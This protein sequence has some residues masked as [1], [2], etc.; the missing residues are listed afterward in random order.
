MNNRNVARAVRIT[1]IAAGAVGAGLY[2]TASIAQEQLQEV[3]VTG[4]RIARPDLEAASPITVIGREA[5][6]ETGITDIG[7]L[8]QRVPSMSGSPIGTTTNNGGDGSVQVDLRGMGVDRTITLINGLRTVDGGDYQTIPPTM[9]ERIEVLKNG[10]SAVYGADAVAGVVNIITRKD[11]DGLEVSLQTADYFDMDRGAQNT[12]GVIIGNSFEG[13]HFVF[14]AEY[15]DQEEAYQRDAPWDFFQ[16]TYYIYPEGCEKQLTAPYTGY[17]DGG[18]YESGSSRIPEG[19]FTFATQGNYI[20]EE[21]IGLVEDDDRLYNFAPV[22]Y[23]QTPYKRTNLFAE[24]GFD[25]SETIRF[26]ASVRGNFRE[27]AQELAPMPYDTGPFL[28]PGYPVLSPSGAILNGISADN[29]YLIQAATAAGLTP[30]AVT[31]AKRR[32][33]EQPRRFEQEVN[34]FQAAA[35]LSGTFRENFDWQFTYNTGHRTRTD[36]DVGQL[37]GSK[38]FNALGP[39]ADLNDDGEPECYR[40]VNDPTSLVPGCVPMNLFGGPGTVTP[41][42]YAYASAILTDQFRER[43]D[44][45]NASVTGEAF[46]LPGGPLGWAVSLGYYD[47]QYTYSPDSAKSSFDVTGNKGEGTD[48]SLTAWSAAFEVLAPVFDNGA[49]AL[50]L[51][52]SV[53]YDDYNQLKTSETTG[54]LGF[55]FNAFADLKLRGTAGT[56]FRAPTILDLYAGRF[57]D[58]PQF[59]DPCAREPLPA[60]CAQL[61]NQP[62]SQVLS[63]NSGNPE[64][65]PESGDT[66]TLGLVWTP[67]IG[68]GALSATVDYWKIKL[69]DAISQLGIQFYLDDCYVDQNAESCSVITRDSNYEVTR[70]IDDLKNIAQQTGEGIDTELRYNLNTGIGDWEFAFLWSHLLERTKTPYAG[71]GKDDLTGRYVDPTAN[72]TS[73]AYA[74]DKINYSVRWYQ[75]GVML[76]YQGEYVSAL[77]ADTFCNCGDGNRPDGTYVQAIDAQL[78]HDFLASYEFKFG[79]KITA[80]VTN[81]TNEKPPYIEVGFNATTDPATY[82]TL[83]R[84]YYLRLSHKFE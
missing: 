28:D 37:L 32:M 58:F 75:Q 70:V 31:R 47:Q 60:G 76:A 54:Q 38:L 29:Y 52:G 39:S 16:N 1:L 72:E 56:V 45:V 14:G 13:G 50:S 25:V 35:T 73:G 51:S 15:V 36:K 24:G 5:I 12:A 53:R 71:A 48:G 83:G 3:I 22:N 66:F 78:Y 30:E 21:G 69:D 11:F 46:D 7:S 65:F 40:D 4:S 18:C 59:S 42:M 61:A 64:L 84:G 82:R 68:P 57:D 77:D 49:Q 44:E 74:Q 20:T 43:M 10:A 8:V 63:V 17:P 67:T 81:F 79:T 33:I 80:G 62:D 19:R 41:E 9:I 23:I 34:Q 2:G 26:N 55:E 27:S 6:A